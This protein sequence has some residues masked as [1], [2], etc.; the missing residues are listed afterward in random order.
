VRDPLARR[1]GDA[2]TGG[3]RLVAVLAAEGAE[4]KARQRPGAR[5]TANLELADDP[6]ALADIAKAAGDLGG[7]ALTG[8]IVPL[9]GLLEDRVRENTDQ[10]SASLSLVRRKLQRTRK[11]RL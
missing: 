7:S 2:R 5:A 1:V 11:A 4:A 9:V 3:P 8:E 6:H 10:R